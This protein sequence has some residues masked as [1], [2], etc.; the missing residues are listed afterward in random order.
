MT[1]T[2]RIL[3]ANLNRAR[4]A[5]RV[6]EDAARFALNDAP[7][8][9]ELKALRHELRACIDDLPPAAGVLEANRDVTG[10]VGT[11]ITSPAEMSRGNLLDVV[12]AAGKRLT[13][14]LRVIEEIAK[15][16]DPRVAQRIESLRYRSY[17]VD[18]QL[19]LRFGSGRAPQWRLCVLLTQSLCRRPWREVL[20]EAVAVSGGGGGGA[21][22]DCIQVREKDM[23][24]GDLVQHVREVMGLVKPHASVI[25]NDR[26]D[27]AL[28]AGADGVHLGQHD[29]S[30]H[31]VRRIA[32][33]ELI[34]GVSTHDLDEARAAIDS[35]ADYCGVGA[36]FP[37]SIK[38]DRGP[39]GPR[40][41]REFVAH[42]PTTPHLAIGGITTENIQ[43][44]LDA[45][46]RGVAVSTAVC[47][48]DEPGAACRAM[49]E[50]IHNATASLC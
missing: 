45:G 1:A 18:Q 26:V 22:A 20:G 24:G 6:M 29:L 4:E 48:A 46:A 49:R 33:R 40:Y 44:L 41:L 35:G 12:I 28:A 27:V 50:A 36:M 15:T 2:L 25:V 21:G 34:V 39:A 5:L 17:A 14:S 9:E 10:D 47:A 31:E 23:P 30:V 8:C 3:D 11:R 32:G 13:E 7:S 38:P 43:Q 16:L 19:Q 42:F 37:T